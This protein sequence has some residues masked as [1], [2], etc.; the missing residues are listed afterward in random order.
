M[1]HAKYVEKLE[2]AINKTDWLRQSCMKVQ[3]GFLPVP[4][5]GLKV[6]AI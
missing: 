1:K 4:F 6:V 2:K 3:L 5:K